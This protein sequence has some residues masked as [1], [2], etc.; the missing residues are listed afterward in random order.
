MEEV[1]AKLLLIFGFSC[2]F[3][4]GIIATLIGISEF[5]RSVDHSENSGDEKPDS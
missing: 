5:I 3:V 4:V 1:I 2:L